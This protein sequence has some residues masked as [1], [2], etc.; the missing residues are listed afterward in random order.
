[1]SI[2]RRERKRKTAKGVEGQYDDENKPSGSSLAEGGLQAA[3]FG[4]AANLTESEPNVEVENL[5]QFTTRATEEFTAEH[6][7]A[8]KDQVDMMKFLAYDRYFVEL[9]LAAM[10]GKKV[11]LDKLE[12]LWKHNR[13]DLQENYSNVE[14]DPNA[15]AENMEQFTARLTEELTTEY[16]DASPEEVRENVKYSAHSHYFIRLNESARS[17]K[18]VT[19][20][21]QEGLNEPNRRYLQQNYPNVENDPNTREI[22]NPV[23]RYRAVSSWDDLTSLSKDMLVDLPNRKI[24]IKCLMHDDGDGHQ[25]FAELTAY[26]SRESKTMRSTVTVL[27]Q[28]TRNGFPVQTYEPF[29]DSLMVRIEPLARYSDKVLF[30]SRDTMISDLQDFMGDH[31]SSPRATEQLKN[32]FQRGFEKGND[33][34]GGA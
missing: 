29:A 9:N 33:L 17:G 12:G 23:G 1:M 21:M 16:P 10:S 11:T 24:T 27:Q 6:P 4:S 32:I 2:E 31:S 8:N 20:N 15:D 7:D 18:Q 5:E 25:V 19:L 3:E 30:A 14:N 26:H 34:E 13:S 28:E 22:G